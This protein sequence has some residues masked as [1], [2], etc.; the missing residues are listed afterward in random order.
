[1]GVKIKSEVNV[2][3]YIKSKN[4]SMKIDFYNNEEHNQIIT[5]GQF[6]NHEE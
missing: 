2:Q 5:K 6:K 1:M 4:H 3:L